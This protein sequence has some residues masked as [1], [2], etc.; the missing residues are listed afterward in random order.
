MTLNHISLS[1]GNGELPPQWIRKVGLG[2]RRHEAVAAHAIQLY[3]PAIIYA[4]NVVEPFGRSWGIAV[5]TQ[6]LF[7]MT[8]VPT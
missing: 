4:V 8:K 6:Q 1:P 3:D 7:K 2:L 5:P